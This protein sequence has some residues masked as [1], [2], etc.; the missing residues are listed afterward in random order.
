MRRFVP[1][2]LT[3]FMLI[4][5]RGQSP[6]SDAETNLEELLHRS[7]V[8]LW[9]NRDLMRS[10]EYF[11]FAINGAMI[12]NIAPRFY[13][14]YETDAWVYDDPKYVVAYLGPAGGWMGRGS[15]EITVETT[16][17]QNVPARL[18]G[19]DEAQGIAVVQTEAA[20]FRPAPAQLKVRWK[21]HRDFYVASLEN[22]LNLSIC[23]LLSAEKQPGLGEHKL[24]VRKL[25]SG[26]PGS[27]V[28]TSD[29][30]FAGFLTTISKEPPATQSH[31]VNLI[32]AER[33]VPSVQRILQ[34]RSSIRGGWLGLFLRDLPREQEGAT[35]GRVIVRNVVAEGP[36]AKAGIA[37]N[38]IVL[39]VNDVSA[40][41]LS[42]VVRMIQKAQVGSPLKLEILRGDKILQFQPTVAI[43][44]KLERRPTYVVEVPREENS[45]VRVR[46][47]DLAGIIKSRNAMFLGIYA[48]DSVQSPTTP[49]LVITEVME[50]TPAAYADFRKGDVILQVNDTMVRNMDQYMTALM[51]NVFA[52][53]IVFRCLRQDKEIRKTISL[54]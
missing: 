52:P 48:T 46:R 49:G 2:L 47:A 43:R 11:R 53:R 42:Q 29:G 1:L 30:D 14:T 35:V 4:S 13:A 16:D 51:K 15:L 23:K 31:I 34:T 27:L 3:C 12:Q 20:T 26:R 24:H 50:N 17:G 9:W 40:E 54:K 6:S 22:G 28:F 38:D 25:R 18:V 44:E 41:N 33:I 7:V 10:G 36:A 19:I 39:K 8:R 32:P 37:E 5:L 21:S 45:A